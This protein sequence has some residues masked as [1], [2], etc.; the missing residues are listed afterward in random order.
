MG[1][2]LY[3]YH[4]FQQITQ[5]MSPYFS[6]ENHRMLQKVVEEYFCLFIYLV[7]STLMGGLSRTYYDGNVKI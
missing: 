4:D 1:L 6:D 2:H 5:C 7:Q 3:D